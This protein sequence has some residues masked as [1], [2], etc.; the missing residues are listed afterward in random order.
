MLEPE[1]LYEDK[2]LVAINK[3]A[4]LLVHR[5]RHTKKVEQRKKNEERGTGGEEPTVVD[6]VLGRYPEIK[7]V[8]DDPENRPGIVHRLDKETS[9]VLLIAKTQ[10]SFEYLKTLFQKHEMAK[11]YLALVRG[12]FQEATGVIDRPIGIVSGSVKRSVRSEKMSKV[13]TTEYR[14]LGEHTIAAREVVSL[15]EVHPKTGRTH[16]IRVHCASIGHPIIGD[17]LYGRR[18]PRESRL[19]LHAFAVEFQGESGERLR[20]EAPPPIEFEPY[21]PL[22]L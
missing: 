12:H 18:K 11:T 2:N 9:G 21:I 20:I 6:W 19:M 3:P 1:I 10:S 22:H 7:T 8:G 13:A 4:G 15:L 17:P 5:A 16:Q 14:V